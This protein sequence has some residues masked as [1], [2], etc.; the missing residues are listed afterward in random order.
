M[1]RSIVV[2]GNCQTEAVMSVLKQVPGL[3]S[4]PIAYY[5]SFERSSGVEVI[6]P[7]ESTIASCLLLLGHP[8]DPQRPFPRHLL[9][10]DC[11]QVRFSPLDFNVFWPWTTVN[12][13]DRRDAQHPWGSF[14]YGDRVIVDCVE[15][16]MAPADILAY[17]LHDAWNDYAPKLDR[18]LEIERRRL[19]ARD[20]LCDVKTAELILTNFT[21]QR[22]FWTRNHPA[23]LLL[24]ETIGRI[25]TV[26]AR[27]FPVF[28]ELD[29]PAFVAAHSIEPFAALQVPIHPKVAEHFGLEWCLPDAQY[30]WDGRHFTYEEYFAE[31]IWHSFAST[32][33]KHV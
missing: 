19:L 14:P 3:Q 26:A 7:T 17:Y 10:A 11:S 2:Y 9:P 24:G 32:P 21:R 27:D 16:G 25:L 23:K 18:L 5:S 20:A 22:L 1:T 29:V 12:P 13:H 8:D 31:M 6:E 4:V 15:K 33:S 28:A 30:A